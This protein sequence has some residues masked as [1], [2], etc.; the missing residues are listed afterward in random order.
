MFGDTVRQYQNGALKMEVDKLRDQLNRQQLTIHDLQNTLCKLIR[1]KET[2]EPKKHQWFLSEIRDGKMHFRPVSDE[3]VHLADKCEKLQEEN[4]KLNE[5]LAEAKL[6]NK[7]LETSLSDTLDV[8][9]S[10]VRTANKL[11]E[12]NKKLLNTVTYLDRR[13]HELVTAGVLDKDSR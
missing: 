7:S 11:R 4:A 9:E 5:E 3:E 2:E 12:E 13:L 10:E 1:K 8:I 6:K